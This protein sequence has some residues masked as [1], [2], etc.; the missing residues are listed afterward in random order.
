MN[1]TLDEFVKIYNFD[2]SEVETLFNEVDPDLFEDHQWYNPQVG[3]VSYPCTSLIYSTQP[4]TELALKMYEVVDRAIDNYTAELPK[5]DCV[6]SVSPGR[7]N[8]YRTGDS[9]DEHVDN[10]H[11]LFTPPVQGVPILSV[12]ALI[13]DDF[14]GGDF[15]LCGQRMDLKAGDVIIFP[16]CFLFPHSVGKVTSGTRLSFVSWA[17]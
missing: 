16:S 7:F 9:M 13:N 2:L 8:I 1:R 14:E 6:A 3:T 10:I 15:T 12:V 11:S 17:W 5:A 4:D